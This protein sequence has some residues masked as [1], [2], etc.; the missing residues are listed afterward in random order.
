MRLAS[1]PFGAVQQHRQA[2]LRRRHFQCVF[3][4]VHA[5]RKQHARAFDAALDQLAGERRRGRLARF[6][7]IVG[8]D[9]FPGVVLSESR[10][11]IVGESADAI[12]GGDIAE[13]RAPERQRIDQRFAQDDLF[14]CFERCF[15]P[16]AAVRSREIQM[17]RRAGPQVFCDLAAVHAEHLPCAIEDWNDQRSVEV[18]VPGLAQDAEPLQSPA[19]LGAGLAVGRRQP[20]A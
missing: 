14:R 13:T 20:Q 2:L 1:Q 5:F 10:A 6:I 16:H 4:R 18:L 3:I 12:A 8:D 7:A 17:Q 19:L 11:V 15:V 9:D